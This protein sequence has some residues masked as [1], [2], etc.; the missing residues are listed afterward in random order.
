[1]AESMIQLSFVAFDTYLSCSNCTLGTLIVP[2]ILSTS[3][4]IP[5]S[6]RLFPEP[7]LPETT[8]NSLS[9]NRMLMSLK[10][11]RSEPCYTSESDGHAIDAFSKE[12]SSW[13]ELYN[14]PFLGRWDSAQF[15]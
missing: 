15:D 1:M 3:P 13:K 8:L 7:V 14:L 12:K 4:S 11:N 10:K 2:P 6:N 5:A 9:G